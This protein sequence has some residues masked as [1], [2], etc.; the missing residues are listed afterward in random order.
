MYSRHSR[1]FLARSV[2]RRMS[3]C[4]VAASPFGFHPLNENPPTFTP[5]SGSHF[6]IKGVTAC[7]SCSRYHAQGCPASFAHLSLGES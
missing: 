6:T 3:L 5:I 1:G 7:L 2:F 4:G